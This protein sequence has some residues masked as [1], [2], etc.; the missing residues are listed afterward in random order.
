M[1]SYTCLA[2]TVVFEDADI[3][4]AHYKTDWHRYNL[5]RKI[6]ELPP[7]TYE[8]FQLKVQFQTQKKEG[9]LQEK[10]TACKVCNKTFSSENAFTNHVKS[11][12]HKELFTAASKKENSEGS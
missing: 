5:K 3:Q 6:A 11:K 8:E 12:K 7:I 9:K 1:A 4:R 10:S 2:C